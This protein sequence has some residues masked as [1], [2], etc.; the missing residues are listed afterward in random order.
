M[1]NLNLPYPNVMCKQ[2]LK[3][4]EEAKQRQTDRIKT[5]KKKG[6]K[7]MRNPIDMYGYRHQEGNYINYPVR[8]GSD[9]YMRTA[10]VLR[11]RERNNHLDNPE[12]VLDV[13]V[14]I[15]PRAWERKGDWQKNIRIVKTTVSCPYRATILPEKYI[16]SDKR[17]SI[18]LTV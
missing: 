2:E 3:E 16:K 18:L 14:A 15:A 12:M 1:T 7:K 6:K 11:V 5:M 9:T 13:A 8:Q 17:Y 4:L 10:K